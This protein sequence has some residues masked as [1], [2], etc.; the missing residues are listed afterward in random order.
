MKKITISLST[1]DLEMLAGMF[2]NYKQV[3][4][5]KADELAEAL[6]KVGK[7]SAELGFA[8]AYYDGNNDVK[9]DYQHRG[10]GVY[11]VI[12]DGNAATFIEFGAGLIGYGHPEPHGMTPG[13]Y[14]T[15]VGKG[16]WANPEGWIY[17]HHSPRSHGNPPA[18]AMYNAKKEI[19]TRIM[20]IAEGVLQF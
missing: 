16:L 20:Y 9:V 8:Q 18:M 4:D 19:E 1:N 17:E 3:I 11:A 7:E 10:D 14:S 15:T 2:E 13:S 5:S 6:A 12:A